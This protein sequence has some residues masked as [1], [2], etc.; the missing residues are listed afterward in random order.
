MTDA[1]LEGSSCAVTVP[2]PQEAQYELFEP[3]NTYRWRLKSIHTELGFRLHSWR[4]GDECSF[5]CTSHMDVPARFEAVARYVLLCAKY[6]CLCNTIGFW[7]IV[8]EMTRSHLYDSWHAWSLRTL[9]LGNGL[10][11]MKSVQG[12]SGANRYVVLV[13]FPQLSAFVDKDKQN[14]LQCQKKWHRN[15]FFEQIVSWDCTRWSW[16]TAF[17]KSQEYQ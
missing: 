15:M 1:A 10:T 4:E 12:A 11:Q 7:F 2:R 8:Y 13:A 17:L 14:G 3:Q 9:N 16:R 5:W 6:T